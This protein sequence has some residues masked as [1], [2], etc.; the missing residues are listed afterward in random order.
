MNALSKS[1]ERELI[2]SSIGLKNALAK[3]KSALTS[4]ELNLT[5]SARTTALTTLKKTRDSIT[6]ALAEVHAQLRSV[7]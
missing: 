1:Q 4:C 2:E 7:R 5:G 6:D 3:V